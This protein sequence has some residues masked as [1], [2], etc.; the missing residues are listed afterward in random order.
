[1]REVA[2][3]DKRSR[4]VESAP[5]ICICICVHILY[6]YIYVYRCI[7]I[8]IIHTHIQHSAGQLVL[9]LKEDLVPGQLYTASVRLQ[10]PYEAQDSPQKITVSYHSTLLPGKSSQKSVYNGSIE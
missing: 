4:R 6:I 8:Y 1:M 7:C 5:H 10:N 9:T 3:L 2:I